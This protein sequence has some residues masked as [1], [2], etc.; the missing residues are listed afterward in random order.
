MMVLHEHRLTGTAREIEGK[1]D[2]Q[3][4]KVAAEVMDARYTWSEIKTL[5]RNKS[6]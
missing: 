1:V 3:I 2:R 4:Q 6:V 5:I